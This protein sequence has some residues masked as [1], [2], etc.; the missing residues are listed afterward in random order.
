MNLL[1]EPNADAESYSD[2]NSKAVLAS[3]GRDG[4]VL[5]AVG[6]DILYQMEEGGLIMLADLGLDD[7]PEG[8]SVWEGCYVQVPGS[9]ECPEDGDLEPIGKF[10]TP[11]DEEWECI[12]INKCPWPDL[13]KVS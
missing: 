11:T 7:A 8:I 5:S 2:Q 3:N 1:Q 4:I 13:P 12:K 10:R 6:Y 9:Y